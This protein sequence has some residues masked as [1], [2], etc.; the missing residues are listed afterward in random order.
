MHYY[1][2]EILSA[3]MELTPEGFLLCRNVPIARIGTMLYAAGEVPVTPDQDGLIRIERLPEDV[4]ADTTIRSFNGKAF[5]IDHP[6][7]DVTPDNW[8]ELAKGIVQDVRRGSGIDDDFLVA[9]VLI[10]EA[11]AIKKVREE[12]L[13][14]VSCGY[15][16]DY[17]EIAPGRGRQFNI[18][19]NHLALVDEGRCGSRC[20]IGDTMKK[21]KFFDKLRAAFQARDEKA[22]DACMKD[23]EAEETEAEKKKRE[24]EEADKKTSDA[25]TKVSDALAELAERVGKLETTK[26]KKAKDEDEE[27]EEEKKKREEEEAEKAKDKKARDS[28]ALVEEAQDTVARVEILSPGLH[29]P[30]FDAAAD[31]QKTRDSLCEL[32]RKALENA[33]NGKNRDAVTPFV[34]QK[35]D[36]KALTWDALKT[37]LLGA[38]EIVRAQNNAQATVTFDGSKAAA[39][40]AKSISEI[41][42]RN[43][44]FWSRS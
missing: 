10:T 5:T 17:E 35:P 20:A 22:F 1:T 43:A 8:S 26:D 2:T 11:A 32:K 44:A 13:R 42:K 40:M 16:A 27:T 34:G 7:V 30:T 36:F 24:E 19:G 6:P 41:N 37:A 31:P 21:L 4:F 39:G 29:L 28:A 9:D 23:A 25:L 15:D 12:G 18:I 14:Q 38:S 33:F 3:N